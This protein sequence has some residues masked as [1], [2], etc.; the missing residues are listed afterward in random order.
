MS[1][2]TTNSTNGPGVN[3]A[4]Y[5]GLLAAVWSAAAGLAVLAWMHYR[6]AGAV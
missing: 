3:Y 1:D 4:H 5:Y 2:H 6:A